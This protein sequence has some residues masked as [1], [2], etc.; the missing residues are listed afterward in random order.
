MAEFAKRSEVTIDTMGK[1][2]NP[3]G[4]GI[5]P[6]SKEVKKR[7]SHHA[8]HTTPHE[9]KNTSEGS[10][11]RNITRKKTDPTATGTKNY[12]SRNKKHGGA[13]KGKW[14]SL[15][16]D[17]MDGSDHA[18][19][20]LD[21]THLDENDPL[22]I[23]EEDAPSSSFL[24]SSSSHLAEESRNSGE[25][26]T[27][28]AAATP[29]YGPLLTLSEFKLR[30]S[31]I[32]REYFDSSDVDEVV[33]CIDELK[34]REYHP[35]VV[36]RAVSLGLD[37]GPR[38]R[39]LVSRLLACLHPVPL[40][41]EEMEAGFEVLLDGVDDL[42]MDV[43]DAKAMVGSFLARAVVDEVLPPAFLSSRNNT[44]PGDVVVEKAVGLLSREHCT[45]RLEKVWGPGDGR[46]VDEL[47]ESMDQLLK[48][49]LLSRELDEAAS[50]VRELKAPHFHHELVKRGVQIAMEEDGRGHG[51]HANGSANDGSEGGTGA[52]KDSGSSAIDAMAA[53]FQ[54]LVNNTIVSEYQVAKGVSRLRKRMDDIKLDVPAAEELLEEFVGMATE[55]GFLHVE[56]EDGGVVAGKEE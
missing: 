25:K 22:Y 32:V 35:E 21:A 53:L 29:I 10:S 33:R 24:L 28:T 1:V 42:V 41:E 50:C 26:P 56:K 40:R 7:T 46:P 55:G 54:F 44:H 18:A 17:A 15:S 11:R 43:P 31:D 23:P 20:M 14:S 5:T 12:D 39:E 8:P 27:A 4:E 30:V 49:Y 36:K 13:G 34:C 19:A 9:T 2:H 45:A 47:K 48:E 6:F 52:D 16:K 3:T 51:N 37:A 38:E